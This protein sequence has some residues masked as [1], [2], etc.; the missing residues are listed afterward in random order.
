MFVSDVS[1]FLIR[2][3]SQTGFFLLQTR[4]YMIGEATQLQEM[5]G[6]KHPKKNEIKTFFFLHWGHV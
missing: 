2:R 4:K 6:I 3:Q 5:D 1:N